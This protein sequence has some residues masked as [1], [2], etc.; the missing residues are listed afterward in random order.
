MITSTAFSSPG[1]YHALLKF[2]ELEKVDYPAFPLKVLSPLEAMQHY[3]PSTSEDTDKLMLLAAV[4]AYLIRYNV[5][6]GDKAL[7]SG[8]DRLVCTMLQSIY[9]MKL[10]VISIPAF[11]CGMASND[12]L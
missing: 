3:I 9:S 2:G 6:S 10:P 8:T 1:E 5:S 12:W 11:L 7:P 4:L